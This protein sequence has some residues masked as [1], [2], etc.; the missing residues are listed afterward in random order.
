MLLAALLT[1]CGLQANAWADTFPHL[2]IDDMCDRA[3][4]IVEG[5]DLGKNKIRINKVLKESPFLPKDS[6]IVEVMELER[7]NRKLWSGIPDNTSEIATRKFVLFLVYQK[8]TGKWKSLSNAEESGKWGSC[9]LF[10]F[11][12]STC[13]GYAQMSNPGPYELVTA[14]YAEGR[15]PETIEDLR[16]AIRTGL[17][18]SR[19]WR[20]S[21]AIVDPV[22]K[23]RALARYL[24]KSTSPKGDKGTYQHRVRKPLAALGRSA[25]PVLIDVLRNRPRGEKLDG[26]VLV[27]YDIGPPAAEAVPEL[28][29][30]LT[31]P[32]RAFTGYVLSA[33][34]STGD[35][36]AVPD[37][38]KYL[39]SDDERLAKDAK[40]ALARLRERRSEWLRAR[41]EEDFD[42]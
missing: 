32:E 28:R 29:S 34:G 38:E 27:L 42:F 23:A 35:P 9:G 19:E 10:W 1:V 16:I 24:L 7:H 40:K 4:L 3:D 21:L 15:I 26:V 14:E 6:R 2:S 31:E 30:L 12:R 37:L 41:T 33:L 13:Y 39:Q 18:N 22:E 20:R 36:R 25:V 8:E 17:A 11:D 5:T